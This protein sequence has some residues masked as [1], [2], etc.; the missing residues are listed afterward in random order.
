MHFH[1]LSL[2]AFFFL[3]RVLLTAT[4]LVLLSLVMLLQVYF[5]SLKG[6]V[7]RE[8]F[9]ICTLDVVECRLGFASV[10]IVVVLNLSR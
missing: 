10:L 6:K 8:P 3:Q 7:V 1:F 2:N 4:N 9:W 5:L